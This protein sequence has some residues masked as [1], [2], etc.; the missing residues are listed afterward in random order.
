MGRIKGTQI[1]VL[2]RHM[3]KANP[4]MFSADFE[5]DKKIVAGLDLGMSKTEKNK[6]AGE[7]AQEIAKLDRLARQQEAEEAQKEAAQAQA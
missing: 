4:G 6:L 7:I 5:E 1:K 2:A 3:L